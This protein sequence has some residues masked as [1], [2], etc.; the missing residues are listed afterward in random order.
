MLSHNEFHLCSR[1]EGVGREVLC[2]EKPSTFNKRNVR[3]FVGEY[4]GPEHFAIQA[5]QASRKNPNITAGLRG[6]LGQHARDEMFAYPSDNPIHNLS[7]PRLNEVLEKQNMQVSSEMIPVVEKWSQSTS[8]CLAL[9][10]A[11]GAGKSIMSA[12][13]LVAKIEDLKPNECVIV[14]CKK[15]LQRN[16]RLMEVRSLAQ[17]SLSIIGLGRALD[18]GADEGDEEEWDDEVSKFLN[19]RLRSQQ[20]EIR[21]LQKELEKYKEDVDTVTAR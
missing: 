21:R 7:V 19:E 1:W 16:A 20:N 3:V 13:A 6:L 4:V 11:P 15:R 10:A 8:G 5:L 17:D 2:L 18:G 12:S 9:A 14:L